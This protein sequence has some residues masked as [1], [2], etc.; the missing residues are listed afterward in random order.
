MQKRTP[1]SSARIL[2]TQPAR[3]I[4]QRSVSGQQSRIYNQR[5]TNDDPIEWIAGQVA[6]PRGPHGDLRRNRN[7][8]ETESGY[9]LPPFS[10]IRGPANLPPLQLEAELTIRDRGDRYFICREGAVAGA[11]CRFSEAWLILG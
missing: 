11:P 4:Q 7:F 6:E 3:P 2:P 1:F 5:R 10:E 8:P 9:A